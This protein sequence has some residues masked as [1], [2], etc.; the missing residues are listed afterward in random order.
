[1]LPNPV[2][3]NGKFDLPADVKSGRVKLLL[4]IDEYGKVESAKLIEST[5]KDH[6]ETAIKV[7]KG[8]VY[9][10]PTRDGKPV[11]AMFY[12]SYVIQPRPVELR[13]TSNKQQ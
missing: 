5:S 11:S 8:T 1:M 4:R 3:V 13:Q 7:A 2:K 10:P 12:K 6:A 9:T